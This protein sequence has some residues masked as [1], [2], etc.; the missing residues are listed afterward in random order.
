MKILFVASEVT[1]LAKTGGLADVA[2]A[3]P[4]N[5]KKLGHDVRIMLP[6]YREVEKGGYG[7][8]K[9]RKSVEVAIGGETKRGLLRHTS[10]DDIPVYLLEN[11]EYFSRDCLYGTAAGDYPDNHRRFAFFCRGVLD[12]LKKLDFRPD[13]IHCHDWQTALIPLLLRHEKGAD[14]FFSNTG[15]IFTIHN[16]AYQGQ[17]PR[18]TLAEMGLDASYFSV[19]CLEFYGK[20]NLMK[21]GILSADLITTVS[22][23]YCREIQTAEMG[24]GLDGVLGVRSADLFG[25]LNGL[26]YDHW[27]P[28]TDRG[29]VKNY[30]ATALAG[31]ALNKKALQQQL[32]L[33]TAQDVPLVGMVSRLSAQKGFDL[34]AETMEKFVG[35]RLQLVILGTGD[36]KYLRLLR[37]KKTLAAGN[38][39]LNIGFHAELAPKIYAGSDI[40]L[41]PSHYEPCGLGQMIALRYGA[42]P[43][44]RRTGGLAD[45]VFDQRDGAKEPNGFFFA[46]YTPEAMWEALSRAL[47]VYGDKAVWRKLM[48]RGMGCDYSWD[49]SARKYEE[50]YRRALAKKGR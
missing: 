38:I 14:L 34:V 20:V 35:S 17:F 1:P 29:I 28:A 8:T 47:K 50:L 18:E 36:E 37:D 16:L 30:T 40:F 33:E 3:L 43:V 22:E 9:G 4:K 31:K 15:V 11:R 41:M 26:D 27:N 32:G 45:T 48:K 46:D 7:I 23:T 25:V 13:V 49:A 6:F 19:D 12:L 21:G 2:A 10:L 5:L 44:V 39:S 24:C 42:V